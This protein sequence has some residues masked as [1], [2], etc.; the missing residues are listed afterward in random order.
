MWPISQETAD[1]VTFT[2]EILKGKLNFLW[3]EC[4]LSDSLKIHWCL[5]SNFSD[6]LPVYYAYAV[7]FVCS[8]AEG[9]VLPTQR[10]YFLHYFT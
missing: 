2:E 4:Q 8:F 3:S 9:F 6:N 7:I 10:A 1:L 5:M